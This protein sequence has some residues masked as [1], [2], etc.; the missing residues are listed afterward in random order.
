M[1]LYL[2]I[3]LVLS[4]AGMAALLGAKHYELSTGHLILAN[5]R[6]KI[7]KFSARM[8]FLFGTAIPL[9]VRWQAGRVYAAANAWL[10]KTA[11]RAV[12]Q[13]EHWL[14]SVLTHVRE[15]TAP[16]RQP[17]EASAF[18]REVGEYKKKLTESATENKIAE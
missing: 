17:G 18:L 1:V 14:E 4:I 15:K 9:Y 2:I 11:A 3:L 5:S 7:A 13:V 6:P 12:V 10:H 8:V 16:N